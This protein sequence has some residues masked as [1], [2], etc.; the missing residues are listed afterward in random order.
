MHIL[1]QCLFPVSDRFPH[2]FHLLVS[3]HYSPWL[4][5][6]H[7]LPLPPP[8][9]VRSLSRVSLCLPK[10]ALEYRPAAT[11]SIDTCWNKRTIR[12]TRTRSV[13]T[14]L[15]SSRSWDGGSASCKCGLNWSPRATFPLIYC[16]LPYGVW[17]VQALPSSLGTPIF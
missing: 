12:A 9:S 14:A 2:T 13:Y 8:V 11:G 7:T 3:C 17:Q 1:R 15:D 5:N 10:P 4:A 16:P 6:G